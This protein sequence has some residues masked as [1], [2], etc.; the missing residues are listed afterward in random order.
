[1]EKCKICISSSII[2]NEALNMVAYLLGTSVQAGKQIT[3]FMLL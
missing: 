3:N 2:I 1:M